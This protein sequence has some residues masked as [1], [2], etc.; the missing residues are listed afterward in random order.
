[1]IDVDVSS[2][3]RLDN[4]DLLVFDLVRRGIAGLSAAALDER[5]AQNIV[6][7]F[8]RISNSG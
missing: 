2:G 7:L 8:Q 3:M 5:R 4:V 1:V 6:S